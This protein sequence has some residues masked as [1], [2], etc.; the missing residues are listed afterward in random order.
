M[1]LRQVCR[2]VVMLVRELL[3]VQT[4]VGRAGSESGIYMII[5]SRGDDV[6]AKTICLCAE[7]PT[8]LDE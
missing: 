6:R 5:V 2:F 4:L 7:T 8:A 1:P 3:R